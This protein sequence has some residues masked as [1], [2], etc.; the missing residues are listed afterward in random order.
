MLSALG[1]AP[2]VRPV[3]RRE[4][5]P[6]LTQR[7]VQ[8]EEVRPVFRNTYRDEPPA[9]T[10]TPR[11]SATPQ[12]LEQAQAALAALQEAGKKAKAKID[13][14]PHL[15]AA[16]VSFSPAAARSFLSRWG[17]DMES[18]LREAAA[19][20]PLSLLERSEWGRLQH[21]L[22]GQPP[23]R[24]GAIEM[25][26]RIVVDLQADAARARY[27]ETHAPKLRTADVRVAKALLSLRDAWHA[28]V[29]L[30]EQARRDGGP[31][32]VTTPQLPRIADQ[33]RAV[34]RQIG[35]AE[36]PEELL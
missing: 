1:L 20:Q 16:E 27:S 2:P 18:I 14:N 28:R 30:A 8:F 13:D 19:G 29:N 21:A 4:E 31:V 35:T 7:N 34:I 22:I 5:I 3:I 9:V 36:K 25:Q 23:H 15:A 11:P 26:R 6:D 12:T 33:I 32:T 17:D 10:R 24:D